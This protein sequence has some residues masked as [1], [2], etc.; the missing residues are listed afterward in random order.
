MEGGFYYYE[1]GFD[2]RYKS[3]GKAMTKPHFKS[4]DEYLAAQPETARA[5]LETVRV[6]LRKAVPA[7]EEVISYNIPAVRLGDKPFL[8]YAGWKQH[9]SLYPVGANVLATLEGEL[10][11]FKAE[12]STLRFPLSEPVPI[13]LIERIA[14][15]RAKDEAAR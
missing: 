5:A 2:P 3:G 10:G 8:W 1:A 7:A 14:S 4:V 12:K 6:A 11:R 15:L 13:A 9:F